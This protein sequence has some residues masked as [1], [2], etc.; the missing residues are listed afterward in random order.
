MAL[1]RGKRLGLAFTDSGV[2]VAEVKANGRARVTAAVS[3]KFTSE[4]NL[5]HPGALGK[6][7]YEVMRRE[8]MSA[9]RAVI[10]LPARWLMSR[11]KQVPPVEGEALSEMLRLTADRAFSADGNELLIDYIPPTPGTPGNAATAAAKEDGVLLLA[12]LRKR[13]EQVR[14]AAEAAGLKVEAITS[15]TAALAMATA[16]TS[17]SDLVVQLNDDSVEFALRDRRQL[18]LLRH[19][20]MHVKAAEPA[21]VVTEMRRVLAADVRGSAAESAQRLLVWDSAGAPEAVNQLIERLDLPKEQAGD[22]GTLAHVNGEVGHGLDALRFAPAI[23]VALSAADVHLRA[24][25]FL[26]SRLAP[27][28]RQRIDQRYRIAGLVAA[29]IAVGVGSLFYVVQGERGEVADLSEQVAHIEPE[30][31]AARE[32]VNKVRYAEGWFDNRPRSLDYL[33]ELTLA[34]PERGDIW[35]TDITLREDRSATISGKATENRSVLE[36]LDRLQQSPAFESV[37]LLYSRDAGRREPETAFSI[38]VRFAPIDTPAAAKDSEP[39][40][41]NNGGSR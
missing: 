11:L 41:A 14:Q 36:L 8:R 4:L 6:H 28:R 40:T 21:S 39:L 38:A 7:L 26:H 27:P 34:F 25:D 1:S 10:G 16:A 2:M 5:E 35:A 18:R 20:A 30:V 17:D 13:V 9:R 32:M 12:A 23:A 29:V 19:V 22:L 24:V 31:E 3:V 15:S 37:K 33:R